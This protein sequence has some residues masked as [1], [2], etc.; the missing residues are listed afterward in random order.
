[1]AVPITEPI[2]PAVEIT[3][4]KHFSE[5]HEAGHDKLDR[6]GDAAAKGQLVSGYESLSVWQTVQKFKMAF[7]VCFAATFAASTDGYQ[8][9]WRRDESSTTILR[10]LGLSTR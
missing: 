4:D 8:S 10:S 3:D 9:A 7:L 5:H 6:L 1:M 2:T